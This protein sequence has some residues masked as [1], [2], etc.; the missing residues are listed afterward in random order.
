[1]ALAWITSRGD[2]SS[3]HWFQQ[4]KMEEQKH[5][6][7]HLDWWGKCRTCSFWLGKRN[8]MEPGRC[9][10]VKSDLFEQETW[11]EGSCKEWDTFDIIAAIH[12]HGGGH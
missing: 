7:W 3:P 4:L 9:S 2:D 12:V 6:D 10:N 5:I 8:T 1:M 11:T